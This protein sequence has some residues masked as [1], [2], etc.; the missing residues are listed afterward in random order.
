MDSLRVVP[1]DLVV[2]ME[3]VWRSVL[4][5]DLAGA[6]PPN[7]RGGDAPGV[8]AC[9]PLAGAW[10]G[11]LSLAFAEDSARRCASVL[12]ATETPSREEMR[13]AVAE[14]A[15][16]V[17]GSARSLFPSP[18]RLGLPIVV[19]G[20]RASVSVPGARAVASVEFGAA[21]SRLSVS[22]LEGNA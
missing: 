13:S 8:A 2:V 20:P 18:T 1:S 22:V 4:G 15:S 14:L 10:R 12:F 16:L 17:A 6:H 3:A 11:V 19:D 21:G 9:V 7:E 5:A